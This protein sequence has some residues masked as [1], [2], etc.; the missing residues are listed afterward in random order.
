MV[1]IIMLQ[2]GKGRLYTPLQDDIGSI[3]KCEVV[4]IDSASPF[5]EHGKTFSMSTARVRPTP[6][7]PKRTLA[8]IS[9]APYTPQSANRFTALTYNLLADLYATVG[10]LSFVRTLAL[11]FPAYGSFNACQETHMRLR[12]SSLGSRA[13]YHAAQGLRHLVQLPGAALRTRAIAS[14][15]GHTRLLIGIA[16]LTCLGADGICQQRCH[17]C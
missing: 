6:S 12:G 16:T 8:P 5:A 9:P 10:L 14:L 3:L 7:P 1:D 17:I 13:S 15:G 4:S 11:L 2:V